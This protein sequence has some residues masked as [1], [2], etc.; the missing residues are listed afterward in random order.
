MKYFL[1]GALH[2][3]SKRRQPGSCDML[4]G[5]KVVR[6]WPHLTCHTASYN[7]ALVKKTD[8]SVLRGIKVGRHNVAQRQGE[9]VQAS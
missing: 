2:G 1:C 5:Q 8:N 7:Y 3:A 4:K 9:K 6:L